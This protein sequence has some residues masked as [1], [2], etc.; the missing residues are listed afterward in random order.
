MKPAIWGPSAWIYL[1]LLTFNYPDNPNKQDISNHRIFL[2]S[3][4]KTLPCPKCKDNYNKHIKGFD[5][6]NALTSKVNFINFV[7][8][9]HNKV[10]KDTNKAEMMFNDFIKLYKNLIDN[11]NLNVINNNETI[12]TLR[13]I[14]LLLLIFIIGLIILFYYTV[15]RKN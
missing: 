5:I 13:K 12:K 4:G 11:E 14:I 2:E 10:N 9:L 15:Y 3:F 8:K 6:N 1:H 7:W